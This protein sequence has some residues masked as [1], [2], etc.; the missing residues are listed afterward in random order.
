MVAG[1]L[2]KAGYFMGDDRIEPRAS[3]L[4]GF[5]EDSEINGI[6]DDLI[7]QHV[8]S[9]LPVLGRWLHRER[10]RKGQRWLAALPLGIE[11][12]VTKT[13]QTGSGN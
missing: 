10:L 4:K 12:R 8:N 7:A 13:I 1:T 3:N 2:S 5:F 9:P 6:N 11:F